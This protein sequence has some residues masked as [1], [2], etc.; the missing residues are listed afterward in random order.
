LGHRISGGIKKIISRCLKK[1]P[2][3]RYQ[4]VSQLKE[5]I[6]NF[7]YFER[8]Q[9][10]KRFLKRL[11]R[12]CT[13]LILFIAG[14][15]TIY[16][17]YIIKARPVMLSLP[18]AAGIC[19]IMA[20]IY[21]LLLILGRKNYDVRITKNIILTAKKSAGLWMMLFFLILFFIMP[22]GGGAPVG[23]DQIAVAVESYIPVFIRNSDGYKLLIRHGAIYYPPTDIIME[24]P[25]DNLPKGK[26]VTMKLVFD[27][28]GRQYESRE[29]S[30][31]VGG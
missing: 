25:L 23:A 2:E 11:I 29:F 13:P 4:N 8:S 9:V 3:K 10:C 30:I 5:D 20:G 6:K 7:H 31:W 28:N 21:F 24:V 1:N 16:Q 17:E 22:P 19:L 27:D 15:I 14:I 12:F 26:E 18:I